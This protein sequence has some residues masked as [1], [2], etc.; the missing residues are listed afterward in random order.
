MSLQ[1]QQSPSIVHYLLSYNWFNVS[2]P[3][4]DQKI[5]TP[6]KI[7]HG[8]CWSHFQHQQKQASAQHHGCI[9]ITTMKNS[10]WFLGEETASHVHWGSH[11]F[12]R[13]W[14]CSSCWSREQLRVLPCMCGWCPSRPSYSKERT[15]GE[16]VSLFILIKT[17]LTAGRPQRQEFL[18]WRLNRFGNPTRKTS[19]KSNLAGLWG[20]KNSHM[21]AV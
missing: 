20:Q 13:N 12:S 14:E 11:G 17:C 21:G 8:R 9:F 18:T 5:N 15:Q 2:L 10:P 7:K 3:R 6:M 16:G 19:F 1:W 4:K